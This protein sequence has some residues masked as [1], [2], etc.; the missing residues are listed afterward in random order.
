MNTIQSIEPAKA[1]EALSAG[2]ITLIDVREADE[3]AHERIH[4]ATLIPLGRIDARACTPLAGKRIVV[5]CKSGARSRQ[6]AE[7]LCSLGVDA[8]SMQGGIDAWKH[9]GLPVERSHNAP[10]PIMRQVQIVVGVGLLFGS[11]LTWWVSPAFLIVP[12]FFGAGLLFA[13]LTG[14]CAL[15]SL[16]G[17]MPWNRIQPPPSGQSCPIR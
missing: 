7:R 6:A 12:A 8:S 3:H 11:A 17:V 15:A 16:L 2:T 5:H 1:A 9:A 10:L 4:G 14:T 13:G